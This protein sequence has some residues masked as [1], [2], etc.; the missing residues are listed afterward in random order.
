MGRS[1]DPATGRGGERRW[2]AGLAEVLWALGGTCAAV[3]HPS[4]GAMAAAGCLGGRPPARLARALPRLAA[5]QTRFA[6]AR[7]H[8]PT[9]QP[10][11]AQGWVRG[12]MPH[13][14]RSRRCA[15][16][17][18][19]RAARTSSPP[20]APRRS[21]WA[22]GTVAPPP[23]PTLPPTARRGGGP[24]SVLGSAGLTDLE[25]GAG[26]SADPLGVWEGYVWRQ[27]VAAARAGMQDEARHASASSQ[28]L[29]IEL[30]NRR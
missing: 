4:L 29:P 3:A 10:P 24:A 14:R 15:C 2:P 6:S 18:A 17:P 28:A 23:C 27:A 20:C 25:R 5:D 7:H 12:S 21:R 26:W 22:L 16:S 13:A 9:P 1:F 30:S 19:R 8:R 11:R